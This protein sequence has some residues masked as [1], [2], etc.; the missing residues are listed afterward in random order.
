MLCRKN[1]HL[2]HL[3]CEASQHKFCY[4]N[5]G[6]CLE[7][8]YQLGLPLFPILH[9]ISLLDNYLHCT[10]IAY[11][12]TCSKYVLRLIKQGLPIW[13]P[14]WLF[15]ILLFDSII[16]PIINVKLIGY[17]VLW[18]C[19]ISLH[20]CSWNICYSSML[21]QYTFFWW[22]IKFAWKWLISSLDSFKI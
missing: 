19:L 21:W 3:F 22:I 14:C 1:S 4:F 17:I 5:S 9:F 11:S 18:T 8:S 10:T 2:Q 12:V 13:N 20:R 7:A 15:I 16:W 6:C